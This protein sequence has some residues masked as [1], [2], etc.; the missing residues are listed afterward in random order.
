MFA[1]P[2]TRFGSSE[3]STSGEGDEDRHEAEKVE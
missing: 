1:F 3:A 2:L